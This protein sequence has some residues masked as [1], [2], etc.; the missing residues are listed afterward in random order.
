ML[1]TAGGIVQRKR[2]IEREK[3]KEG[4]RVWLERKVREIGR[5]KNICVGVLVWRF[6]NRTPAAPLG[7][8][9]QHSQHGRASWENLESGKVRGLLRFWEGLGDDMK[10]HLTQ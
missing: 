10:S 5:R 3:V 1:I 2:K 7:I 4:L 6:S 8:S 9:K